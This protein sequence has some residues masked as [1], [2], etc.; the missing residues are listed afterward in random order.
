MRMSLLETSFWYGNALRAAG[1][2]TGAVGAAVKMVQWAEAYH[3]MGTACLERRCRAPMSFDP[4]AL[5]LTD[6]GATAFSVEAG[7]QSALLAG[8]GILDLATAKARD[9]GRATARV[10][11]LGDLGFLGQLAERAVERGLVVFVTF[12]AEP[13]SGDAEALAGLYSQGR[14]IAAL[15]LEGEEG[16]LWIELP[17]APAGHA[18]L[19]AGETALAAAD[20][21]AL[22]LEAAEIPAP[23]ATLACFELPPDDCIE[24]A[25]VLQTAAE[26]AGL[27]M[28]KS[29]ETASLW[30]GVNVRGLDV[31]D[32]TWESLARFALSAVVPSSQTSRAQAG[33]EH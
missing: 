33:A 26:T 15:P 22:A 21:A 12:Q 28:I 31:A 30:R 8:P 14:G 4:A 18:R 6:E 1:L 2:P 25:V 20:L 19:M 7:G 27:F 11:G 5:R 10:T 24:L 9:A 13:G 16:P 29:C 3:G 23:G 17:A 32:E